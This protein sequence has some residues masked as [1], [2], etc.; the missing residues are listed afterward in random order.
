M[1]TQNKALTW[2]GRILTVL[3]GGMLCFSGVMKIMSPPEFKEEWGTRLGY[4]ERTAMAI[5]IVEICCAIIYLIPQTAIL[6]AV[7]LTGYLGGAVATHVRIEDNQFFSPVIGGVL[8]WLTLFLRDP[9]VRALL[10]I[11]WSDDCC[12]TSKPS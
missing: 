11:R 3:V 7:L 2:T 10:P 12:G 5:G 6:G 4:P 8:V 1:Q 9:R